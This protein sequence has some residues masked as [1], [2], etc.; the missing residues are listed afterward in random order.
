M[1]GPM[2]S[3]LGRSQNT[4]VICTSSWPCDGDLCDILHVSLSDIPFEAEKSPTRENCMLLEPQLSSVPASPCTLSL[5][6]VAQG[7]DRILSLTVCSQARTIEVYSASQEG[8]EEEYLG[9]SRGEKRYTFASSV[10]D[11]P[12]ILY[13]THLKLDFPVP[14]CKVKLLSLGGKQCVVLSKI[15]VQMT[16]VPE[17]CSQGSSVLGPSINLERVQSIMDSMGG[18]LSPGA[19]QLMSMVRAQ[20]KHQAPFGVHLLQLF[21]NFGLGAGRQQQSEEAVLPNLE[22]SKIPEAKAET[23]HSL[24]PGLH[25]PS[26]PP[27]SPQNKVHQDSDM[28]AALSSLLQNQIDGVGVPN[29]DSLLP[30]L[31]NMCVEK[32]I[33]LPGHGENREKAHLI[34]EDEKRGVDLEKLVSDHMH[35]MERT[36]MDHIDQRMKSLQEHLDARLDRMMNLI[37]SSTSLSPLGNTREKI[38]NGQ[39]EYNGKQYSD[40]NGIASHH[41]SDMSTPS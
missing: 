7:K 10:E 35:R 20:Q 36:L 26:R 37:Q 32:N 39:T 8:Q 13:E 12:I 6:C 9:T 18:K 5:C 25:L 11:S 34:T 3:V 41:F 14:S 24:T 1:S 29:P 31:R 17:R 2:S 33:S 22:A 28:K 30:F 21:G 27:S 38:A 19:E 4:P 15:S 40:C 23:S 16:S